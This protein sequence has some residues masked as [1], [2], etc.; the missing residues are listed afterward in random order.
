[1]NF[2]MRIKDLFMRLLR[3]VSDGSNWRSSPKLWIWAFIAIR[4]I[5]AF[6]RKHGLTLGKKN[7][8]KDHVFLTGAGSGLG[9]HMAIKLGKMGCKL[10]LSD[11]NLQGVQETK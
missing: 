4:L 2:L 6:L 5:T 10:S 9:R 11:I 8:S 3:Y 7:L 1:M